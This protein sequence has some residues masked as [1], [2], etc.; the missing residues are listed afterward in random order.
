MI[1]SDKEIREALNKGL[2]HIE[3]EPSDSQIKTSALDLHLDGP[4]HQYRSDDDINSKSSVK[5]PVIIDSRS[6][7]S[8]AVAQE[9]ADEIPLDKDH[10]GKLCYKMPPRTFWLARTMERVVLPGASK[11]AA[12]VEGRSTLARF[13]LVVHMTA[14]TIHSKFQGN[15]VLEMC[16]FGEYPIF[17]YPRETRICQLVFERLGEEPWSEIKSQHQGQSGVT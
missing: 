11:I 12:R 10:D 16:N 15:I 6:V 4:V 7:N 17:L 2:I 13:G 1:L 3:P 14:P 8:H 9:F 5:R